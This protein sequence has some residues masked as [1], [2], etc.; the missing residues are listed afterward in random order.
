MKPENPFRDWLESDTYGGTWV[1]VAG[2]GGW[3]RPASLPA[4]FPCG[5]ADDILAGSDWPFQIRNAGPEIWEFSDGRKEAIL[6]PEH[7]AGDTPLQPLAAFFDPAGRGAWLEP[8]Q[9]FVLYHEASPKHQANGRISW[10]VH[11]EDGKPDEIARWSPVDEEVGVLE[12]RRDALFSFMSDFDFDLAIYYEE[13]RPT[14]EVPDGWKED[15]R[16]TRRAWR[17]WASDIGTEVRVVLRCVTIVPRPPA[18]ERKE[19]EY[20]GQTLEYPVGT[21][22][23]TGQPLMASYPGEPIAQTAWPGAGNDNFLTPVFFKRQVLTAYLDEPRYY[24]VTD[25]YIWAGD[26]WGIPIAITERGNVQVWLGDLGRISERA[27]RHWQQYAIA[28]DDAVPDWRVAQDLRAEFADPPRDE[29]VDR[30]KAGVSECNEAAIAYCGEPLFTPVEGM[31]EQRIETL[32]TPLT[33][34]LPAFQQQVTSLAILLVDHLNIDFLKAAEA[35]PDGGPLKRLAEWLGSEFSLSEADAKNI[36]RGFYAVYS[37]RSEA[38]AAHRAGSRASEVLDR[39][40][41]SLENLP[42]GFESLAHLAADSLDELHARLT[43]LANPDG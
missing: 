25:S 7:H 31:N 32:H 9:S 29:G 16:E 38:G 12:I 3:V 21:D 23:T 40:G 1:P 30:V 5:Q 19:T 2:L 8:I 20:I 6:H 43:G 11:D 14:T 35:P 33:D 10:E 15:D 26:R 42:V 24:T 17:V 34:S 13:N 39:A 18:L 36:L 27:Q 4:L 41:I 28:D 22:P 37:I